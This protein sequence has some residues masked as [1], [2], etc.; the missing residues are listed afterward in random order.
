MCREPVGDGAKRVTTSE[1]SGIDIQGKGAAPLNTRSWTRPSAH[2][3][4]A[5]ILRQAQAQA[6][7]WPLWTP[8]TFGCGCGAYFAL[9]SEPGLLLAAALAGLFILAAIVLRR[10]GRAPVL[11]GLVL[12]AAFAAAG[13]LSG[14]LQTLAMAGPVRVLSAGGRDG[15]GMRYYGANATGAACA[16]SPTMREGGAE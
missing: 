12:L 5:W 14:K 11:A 8:V 16:R 4:A 6:D 3:L 7:R 9:K 2:G 10:W 1:G 13:V 15:G